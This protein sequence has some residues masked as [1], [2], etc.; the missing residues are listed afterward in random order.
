MAFA[1]WLRR[2]RKAAEGPAAMLAHAHAVP[3]EPTAPVP[4]A[5]PA[6]GE[7]PSADGDQ[8]ARLLGRWGSFSA[9]QRRMFG[10]LVDEIS[11]A[12]ADMECETSALSGAFQELAIKAQAQS[13]RV[14]NLS[15]LAETVQVD[16]EEL[17]LDE[18]TRLFRQTLGDIVGKIDFLSRHA[19][20]V[21]HALDEVAA[22]LQRVGDCIGQVDAIN[23]QTKMLA[24][25]ARIEAVRVG[26]A[27]QAFGVVASEIGELSRSTQ[28]LAETMRTQLAEVTASVHSSHETLLQVEGI[29]V[30]SSSAGRERLDRLV[31]ALASRNSGLSQIV[32]AA[33]DDGAEISRRIC[34]VITGL[35]FQDRVGQRM[36]QVSDILTILAEAVSELQQ[37]SGDVCP[38]AA[39]GPSEADVAWLKQLMLRYRLSEM[40][41]KFVEGVIEGRAVQA[42]PPVAQA[43]DAGSID[44]F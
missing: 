16:G 30:G 3:A 39:A 22:S 26:E 1:A 17:A 20:P 35:Q 21:V 10:N 27:G 31:Q 15:R 13:D 12:S 28:A 23:R 38:R 24:I 41:A 33:A 37:E 42:A 19:V 7:P 44:L 34:E 18:I 40:R 32:N 9:V 25:N 5:A 43:R 11:R 29:D 4:P 6:A 36:E 8:A 2:D 14:G